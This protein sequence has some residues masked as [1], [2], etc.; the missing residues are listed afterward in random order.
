MA[1]P[2]EGALIYAMVARGTVVLAEHTSYT[3]NFR[4]IAAQCLHRMPAGNNRFIYTCD[5]HTFN[6][7]VADGYAY[8]VAATESAGWQIPMA[9]LE[10]IKEDFNKRYAG[11]KAATA[12]ANSLSREFGPRLGAQMQYCRDHP[13][14]VSRLSRVKAQVDQVK[15][16]MMENIDKVIDRG[17]QIDG[18]VTRTEQLHN[19]AADFRQQG[20]RVR[21]R[22]W[23]QNMK[24]KLIVLG[25]VIALILI[26]ILSVYHGIRK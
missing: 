11:G 22:M 1:Q 19:Q 26:I 10:M 2:P 6:F 25:I 17:E 3:G 12:T 7:L 16:I 21:R 13:E 20:T 4:D 8:C 5:A 24:T 15:G 23:Y 18:L 9:F 14:E